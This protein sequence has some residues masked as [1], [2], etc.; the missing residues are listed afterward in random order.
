MIPAGTHQG[1]SPLGASV[2]TSINGSGNF[3]QAVSLGMGNDE[4]GLLSARL[5]LRRAIELTKLIKK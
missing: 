2:L 1:V 3:E 4:Q 5:M